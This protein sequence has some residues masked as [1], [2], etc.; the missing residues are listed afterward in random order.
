[1]DEIINIDVKEEEEKDETEEKDTKTPV[2][3]K[4]EDIEE[5]EEDDEDKDKSSSAV[6]RNNPTNNVMFKQGVLH[7]RLRLQ[8]IMQVA[9][10]YG[11]TEAVLDA[12]FN[13][14][15]SAKDLSFGLITAETNQKKDYLTNL[16]ADAKNMT[17]IARSEGNFKD[18]KEKNFET[19]VKE[20][21]SIFAKNKE[22]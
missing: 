6:A 13:N 3:P 21:A 9:N 1:M 16:E 22:E 10:V 20:I 18:T 14:P 15:I 17:P 12:M 8:E 11:M 4:S 5:E 19:E 7:E 2:K